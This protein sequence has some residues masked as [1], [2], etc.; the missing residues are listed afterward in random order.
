MKQIKLLF[1]SILSMVFISNYA[2]AQ[3]NAA[4][5]ILTDN[6]GLVGVGET[7]DLQVTVTNTGA[8]NSIGVNKVRPQIS[9]PSAIAT[10]LPNAQQ[11]GLPVGWIITTNTGG[12]ITICNG[13]DIIAPG[14][15]RTAIIKIQGNVLGGPSTI[16][17]NLQFGPGSGVCT[18][19]GSLPGDAAGDNTSQTSITVTN[20]TPLTLLSF[21][22]S[23]VNCNSTLNWV[24][25]NEINTHSFEIE[26]NNPNT[27]SWEKIGT[28]SAQGNSSIQKNYTFTDITTNSQNKILYRLK[29]IDL[30]RSFKYSPILPVMGNC[31]KAKAMIYPNPVKGDLLFVSMTGFDGNAVATLRNAVGQTIVTKVV[32]NGTDFLNITGL[33]DGFYILNIN[34]KNNNSYNLKVLIQK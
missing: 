17:A 15:A 19:P 10:A 28:V 21:N 18:G 2:T 16:A 13:T 7:I 12:V 34:D 14:V 33:S 20:T 5:N 32:K 8:T 29:M 4:I 25:T 30:D 6:S 24:T 31:L 22:A 11:T 3:T 26:R 9:I 1:V 23:V 27:G